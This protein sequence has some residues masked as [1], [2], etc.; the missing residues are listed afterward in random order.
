MTDEIDY[1][2]RRISLELIK[3]VADGTISEE[4]ASLAAKDI[5]FIFDKNISIS[6]TLEE[7][8]D[9]YYYLEKVFLERKKAESARTDEKMLESV[10]RRLGQNE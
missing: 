9:K 2:K 5:I 6:K 7:I 10:R 8:L 1:Y 4:G 3:L